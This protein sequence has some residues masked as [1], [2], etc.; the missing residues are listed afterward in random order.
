LSRISSEKSP[1]LEFRTALSAEVHT[2][3]TIADGHREVNILD[4][5]MKV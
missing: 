4:S 5:V 1:F 2:A 3:E